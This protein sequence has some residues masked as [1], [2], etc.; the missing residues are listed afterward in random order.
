MKKVFITIF[1][2][3]FL[4][5]I[6]SQTPLSAEEDKGNIISL[7]EDRSHPT[8]QEA[9]IRSVIANSKIYKPIFLAYLK[10][11]RN[12]DNEAERPSEAVLYTIGFTRDKNYFPYL[13]ELLKTNYAKDQCIYYCGVVFA[14]I[15]TCP[16][17]KYISDKN[18]SAPLYD[19]SLGL[20]NFLTTKAKDSLSKRKEETLKNIPVYS[21]EERKYKEFLDY[22]IKKLIEIAKY[23]ANDYDRQLNA[24]IT[25]E[26]LG[27][28]SD[29]ATDLLILVIQGPRDASDEFVGACYKGILNILIRNNENRL[30]G[31]K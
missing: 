12:L 29:T 6:P 5:P 26:Y 25:L 11:K 9:A 7:I 10:K 18:D 30:A 27:E 19:F 13:F 16:D 28:S 31:H 14:A 24:A 2:F 4:F 17:V 8:R 1:F 3:F 22:P 23:E 21:D 15:L 20:K